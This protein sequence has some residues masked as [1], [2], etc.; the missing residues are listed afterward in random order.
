M[1]VMKAI[2]KAAEVAGGQAALAR[3]IGV[4]PPAITQWIN[5][6]RPVPPARAVQIEQVTSIS[7]KLL[8]PSFPWEK[9][10]FALKCAVINKDVF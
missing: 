8:C 5:G 1:N 6:V 7:K 4:S 9:D 2:L 10:E 3:L